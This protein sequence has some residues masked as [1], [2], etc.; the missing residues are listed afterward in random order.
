MR[1]QYLRRCRP[2]RLES[3]TVSPETGTFQYHSEFGSVA[4]QERP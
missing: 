1:T 4:S 2:V 3:S